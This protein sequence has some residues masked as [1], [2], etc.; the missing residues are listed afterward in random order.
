MALSIIQMLILGAV[1]GITE[2]IPISSSAALVLILS[3]FYNVTSPEVL[4]R[5][6]LFFHM[7]T[8]LAALVYFRKEVTEIIKNIF[9]YKYADVTQK[10]TINFLF[11]STIIT[12][13]IGIFLI[14]TLYQFEDT[15]T[16]TGKTISFAVGVFLLFTGVIQ[17]KIKAGGIK[18]ERDL[19]K[20][21]GVLLGVAQ[22]VS[23]IPG[24]SRSGLTVSTLLL[25]KF[26]DTTALRLSFLMSLPVILFG[27]IFLNLEDFVFTTSG[28]YGILASFVLGLLTIH[29]LMKLSR[30]INFGWFILIF[31]VLMLTSVL[32]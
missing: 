13:V 21:D 32:I 7:G 2:W 6:A 4:V 22:G 20:N 25:K 1:Q 15:L 26:D 3:N 30:K 28:L 16:F 18:R 23:A 24:I 19:K 31:A 14:K 29:L 10:K 12:G 17:L 8:F 11:I 5:T 27:N 9:H